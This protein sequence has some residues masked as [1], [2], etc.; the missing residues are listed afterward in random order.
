MATTVDKII[1]KKTPLSTPLENMSELDELVLDYGEFGIAQ[2]ENGT[3]VDNK[4]FIGVGNEPGETPSANLKMEILTSENYT[5]FAPQVD[6]KTMIVNDGK[7]TV[8]IDNDTL[9]TDTNAPYEIS[10]NTDSTSLNEWIDGKISNSAQFLGSFTFFNEYENVSDETTVAELTP[11]IPSNVTIPNNATY[12]LYDTTANTTGTNPLWVATFNGSIWEDFSVAQLNGVDITFD[13]LNNGDYAA[14]G[15]LLTNPPAFPSGQIFWENNI[16]FSIMENRQAAPDGVTIDFN[17]AGEL[18]VPI[19]G[20]D[21]GLNGRVLKVTGGSAQWGS[22]VTNSSLDVINT[23]DLG[24]DGS[25]TQT[26]RLGNV[27]DVTDSTPSRGVGV[28]LGV[29]QNTT[30]RR[31]TVTKN[32]IDARSIKDDAFIAGEGIAFERDNDDGSTFTVDVLVNKDQFDF[33]ANNKL[34]LNVVDGGDWTV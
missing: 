34:V 27:V 31:I 20:S 18:E 24:T 17:G 33:D 26:V 15:F 30:T 22:A 3:D 9:K 10:V 23:I 28:V 19:L 8:N 6:G 1:I 4:L 16:N 2:V 29:T 25:G 14:L 21:I 13:S 11:T 12:L 5:D 32:Q 7:L